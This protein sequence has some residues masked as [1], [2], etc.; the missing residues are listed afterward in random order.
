MLLS[1]AP[2]DP[3]RAAG[4]PQVQLMSL[5]RRLIT[6]ID[7]DPAMLKAV[8]RLLRVKG[9]E[10]ETF[11][12]AEA[13]L[14]ETTRSACLVLDVHLVGISGI[15]LQRHLVASGRAIPIIFITAGDDDAIRTAAAQAGCVAF[16]H[17][18]FLAE[19]LVCAIDTAI[20]CGA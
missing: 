6:V 20:A 8:E 9:F 7:D 11:A 18:P 2:P 5:G 10:V 15:E 13:F 17:K 12:S 4:A 1:W 3:L 14:Q 16:L 19:A